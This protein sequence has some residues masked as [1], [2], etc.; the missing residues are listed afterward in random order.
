MKSFGKMF[1]RKKGEGEP[2]EEQQ[3]Q[4]Q[5]SADSDVGG[6]ATPRD[7]SALGPAVGDGVDLPHADQSGDDDSPPPHPPPPPP[8]PMP[9]DNTGY[10]KS[11]SPLDYAEEGG[12]GSE[13]PYLREM[14]E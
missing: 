5:Q 9:G 14:K 3:L 4:Q 13:Y 10:Y 8:P 12:G 11:T 2:E 1:K 7:L 6:E